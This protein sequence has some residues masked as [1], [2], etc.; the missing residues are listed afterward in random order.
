MTQS[1]IEDA[2]IAEGVAAVDELLRFARQVR[3]LTHP[4]FD[5]EDFIPFVKSLVKRWPPP[6]G[7][8]PEDYLQTA[9][10]GLMKAAETYDPGKGTPTTWIGWAVRAELTAARRKARRGTVRLEDCGPDEGAPLD[11]MD[12]READPADQAAGNER[13]DGLRTAVAGLPPQERDVISMRWFDGLTLREVAAKLGIS[14][15]RCGQVEERAIQ[16][17]RLRLT[18]TPGK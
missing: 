9:Y 7:I 15:T 3:R 8:D 10:L 12:H 16:R 11:P 2:R 18:K 13:A 5:P 4:P 6:P 17:L 14:K 1:E